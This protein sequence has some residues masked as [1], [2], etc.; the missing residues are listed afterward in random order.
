MDT[1]I[2]IQK[3]NIKCYDSPL[4]K[5][6]II[7]LLLS[8]YH[9]L[10]LSV[11]RNRINKSAKE[12]LNVDYDKYDAIFC[13]HFTTVDH[14]P[15]KFR[16]KII[17]HQHN[18][19]YVMWER[20]ERNFSYGLKR[21]ILK[22]EAA[23]VKNYE[24]YI[25][26]TSKAVLAVSNNDK[27]ALEEIMPDNVSCILVP[28]IA[29]TALFSLQRQ[30]GH[31]TP[32]ILYVGSLNWEANKAGIIWFL[33]NVWKVFQL[34]FPHVSFVIVGKTGD[35]NFERKIKSFQG[36]KYL[37]YQD[38]VTSFYEA[39]DIF[40]NPIF[41]GSGIKIKNLNAFAAGIPLITTDVGIEGMEE[42]AKF[43]VVTQNP[44]KW[45]D[46]LSEYF[47]SSKNTPF[48]TQL[49]RAHTLKFFSITTLKD[50]LKKLDELI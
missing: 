16:H 32:N 24:R 39:A 3:D 15:E 27:L 37:G 29:D 28:S 14:V 11:F 2:K 21:L 7:N 46:T 40:V 10:P 36:V 26:S 23:R 8:Y 41:F 5:R 6:S 1:N 50:A 48:K 31:I 45:N 20:A 35:M 30:S 19:E 43:C 25:C 44:T 9:Y 13:D 33:E 47:S 17:L 22:I 18:A 49:A 38:D 4:K 12:R 34:S 42:L